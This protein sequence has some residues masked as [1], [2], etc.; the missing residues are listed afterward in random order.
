MGRP[1]AYTQELADKICS[2][3]AE[4]ESL[5]A[6]CKDDPNMPAAS[7]VR[8]WVTDD[9][10]GF[11]AQY[12]R[13]R[14]IGLDHQAEYIIE[15]A[16]TEPDPARARVMIDARKWHLSKMAPKRY[17]EKLAAEVTGSIQV[18]RIVREIVDPK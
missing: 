8:R 5:L 4:G 17:G 10:K 3:L 6:I 1:S 12:A 14:D 18:E 7:T 15:I 13:A 11:A 2:W 9:R 16:D